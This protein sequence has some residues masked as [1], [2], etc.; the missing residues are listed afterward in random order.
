MDVGVLVDAFG[1]MRFVHLERREVVL[2]AISR[3]R[4]EDS[5]VWNITGRHKTAP[6][7][8]YDRVAIERFVREAREHNRAWRTWFEANGI[9]PLS[10]AYEDL[11]RDRAGVTSEVLG[12][13]GVAADVV[14]DVSNVRMADET[15]Q[16]WA[17]RFR[18]EAGASD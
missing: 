6:A 12:Y 11:D 4:A 9:E 7:A 10:V 5:Q 8:S 14:A 1:A 17:K 2:Q 3:H 18:D 13:L 15:T 16:R